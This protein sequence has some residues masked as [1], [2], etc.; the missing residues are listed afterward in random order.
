MEKGN[1]ALR[2]SELFTRLTSYEQ[3]GA[4]ILLMT[5]GT[6]TPGMACACLRA[7][8]GEG[9]LAFVRVPAE[10]A[11]GGVVGWLVA[12]VSGRGRVPACLPACLPEGVV[13]YW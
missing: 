4:A 11:G 10:G 13:G 3:G 9:G 6:D 1:R 2:T 8:R 7:C 5:M 12:G